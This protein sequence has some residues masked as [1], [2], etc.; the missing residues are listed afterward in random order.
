MEKVT[1][2][3]RREAMAL[4][5][6][7]ELSEADAEAGRLLSTREAFER[8]SRAIDISSVRPGVTQRRPRKKK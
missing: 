3:M 8:A 6:L 1:V 7:L 2:E 5:K 4:K